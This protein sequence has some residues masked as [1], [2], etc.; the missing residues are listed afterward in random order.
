MTP[1]SL[2]HFTTQVIVG[3][4][5]GLSALYQH[6]LYMQFLYPLVIMY[7]ICYSNFLGMLSTAV[8]IST[9]GYDNNGFMELP[10]TAGGNAR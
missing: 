6:P 5:M 7:T 3:M 4:L 9:A 1:S 10:L 2:N 8:L